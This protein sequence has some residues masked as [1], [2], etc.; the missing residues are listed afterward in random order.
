[1][2]RLTKNGINYIPAIIV[3]IIIFVLSALS[4]GTIRTFNLSDLFALDKLG[5][6]LAYLALSFLYYFGYVRSKK[7][8][9]NRNELIWMILLCSLYGILL[10]F[11]QLYFFS[12]RCFEVLDMIANTLGIICGVVFGIIM[13]KLK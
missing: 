12:S 8:N 1:M 13:I 2:N 7:R 11:C 4:S 5:H 10:E 6:F 9:P 3:T